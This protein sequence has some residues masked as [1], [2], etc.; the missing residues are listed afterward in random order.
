M[1]RRKRFIQQKNLN[2]K[3]YWK[4]RGMPPMLQEGDEKTGEG[5]EIQRDKDEMLAYIA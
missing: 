3:R 5:A 2:S 4:K 1:E